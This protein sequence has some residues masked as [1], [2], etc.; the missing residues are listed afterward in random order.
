[1]S[2]I[3]DYFVLAY[4]WDHNS[5][6]L[7][8]SIHAD[9]RQIKQHLM[10]MEHRGTF[11]LEPLI[12]YYM[13]WQTNKEQFE[14]LIQELNT[15][16]YII[17]TLEKRGFGVNLDLAKALGD[18]LLEYEGPIQDLIRLRFMQHVE[19]VKK[20]IY[21][22]QEAIDGMD[23][24]LITRE[25]CYKLKRKHKAPVS[26]V[27]QSVQLNLEHYFYVMS[28]ETPLPVNTAI[29]QKMFLNLG[30]SSMTIMKGSI[31]LENKLSAQ[32]YK[33]IAKQNFLDMYRETFSSLHLFTGIDIDLLKNIHWGLSK[34]LV[35]NAGNFRTGDFPDRNGVTFE[36]VNFEREI[37]EFEGVMIETAES[38]H[39]FGAFIYN[40]AR[41]YYLFIGIHPFWDSN[42]RVGKCFLNTM[43]IKKGIAPIS[44]NNADEVFALPRYGGSVENMYEYI[45]KRILIAVE[46]YF[47]E[48]WKIENFGFMSKPIY[49]VSFDSG[50]HFRQIDYWPGKLEVNFKAYVINDR[51]LYSWSY[52]QQVRIVFNDEQDLHDMRVH[53][54]FT[55]Q[56]EDTWEHVFDMQ[57]AFFI[58]EEASENKE[59]RV[60]DVD[61]VIDLSD[62]HYDYQF[63]NCCVFSN[64]GSR[65]FTNKGLN[66]TFKFERY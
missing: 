63:F 53:C 64:D 12:D 24:D 33:R 27:K 10:D 46:Q 35:E 30:S 50:F 34:E 62:Y 19:D 6:D 9:L 5:N 23:F 16:R 26:L 4:N 22:P 37:A 17:Q 38:F 11:F 36:Y 51:S 48:R 28:Q 49:N 58:K 39:D 3:E 8:Q 13:K 21:F 7:F 18:L 66:Y 43:L 20:M 41:T 45:K 1:M 2:H 55:R 60:F 44:F 65:I 40:L 59:I 52:Q 57:K 31:G 54:G 29:F 32:E 42:G 61:F 15:R 56:P 47:Y 14:H 25:M